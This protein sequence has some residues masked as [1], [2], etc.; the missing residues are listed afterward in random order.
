MREINVEELQ[1]INGGSWSLSGFDR[2][3]IAG[4][5]SGAATGAI[6]GAIAGDGVGALPG[7]GIGYVTGWIGSGITY[8]INNL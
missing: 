5:L 2:A 8:T 1:N 3:T 7:A 6:T 4:G